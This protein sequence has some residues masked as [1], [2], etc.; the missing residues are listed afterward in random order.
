MSLI[1]IYCLCK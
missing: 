1:E